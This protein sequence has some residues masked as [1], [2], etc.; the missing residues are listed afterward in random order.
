MPAVP[1]DSDICV[2]VGTTTHMRRSITALQLLLLLGLAGLATP[3]A[4]LANASNPATPAPIVYIAP[5][6][7]DSQDC[8]TPATRCATLQHGLD[9]LADGGEARLAA[10]NY[11]GTTN[12]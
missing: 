11:T 3:P 8:A 4:R 10:G 9:Q 5:D 7:D 2:H 1:V 6:G 12:L